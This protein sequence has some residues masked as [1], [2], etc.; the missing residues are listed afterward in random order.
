MKLVNKATT[1]RELLIE[2]TGVEGMDVRI[3]SEDPIGENRFQLPVEAYGVDRFRMIVEAE[4]GVADRQDTIKVTV[5]DPE[6]GETFTDDVAFHGG[7]E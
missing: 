5:T 2:V 3:V 6:T 7:E 4:S 1:D